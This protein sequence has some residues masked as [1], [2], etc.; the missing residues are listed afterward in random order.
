MV[1]AVHVSIRMAKHKAV[2]IPRYIASRM[3]SKGVDNMALSLIFAVIALLVTFRITAHQLRERGFRQFAREHSCEDAPS[4]YTSY[5]TVLQRLWRL[6][7]YRRSGEDILDDIL[8][9]DFDRQ[10]TFASIGFTGTSI[11][12]TI[13]PANI[14]ALLATQFNDF[15]TGERR[16]KAVAPVLG[17]SIFSS[18]GM[19]NSARNSSS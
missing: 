7:N 12:G 19:S 8:S 4:L 1:L 18:D 14:Q 13:D 3:V 11:V 5:F 6:I 16:Y 10:P 9:P 17:R 2:A 15:D